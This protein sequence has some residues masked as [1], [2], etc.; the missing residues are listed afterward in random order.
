MLGLAVGVG[1]A[2]E[3]DWAPEGPQAAEG[4]QYE[5][6]LV[7]ASNLRAMALASNLLIIPTY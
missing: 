1:A 3:A 5:A 2:R 7:M 6:K 4:I